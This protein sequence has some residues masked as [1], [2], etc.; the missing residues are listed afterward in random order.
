VIRQLNGDEQAHG[1]DQDCI[2]V[3]PR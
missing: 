2:V 1:N 3:G